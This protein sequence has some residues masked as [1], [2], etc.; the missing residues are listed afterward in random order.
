MPAHFGILFFLTSSHSFL[1]FKLSPL[2][3]NLTKLDQSPVTHSSYL[4]ISLPSLNSI[5]PHVTHISFLYINPPCTSFSFYSVQDS[6]RS[7][8]HLPYNTHI[9]LVLPCFDRHCCFLYSYLISTAHTSPYT[10]SLS[11]L[12]LQRFQTRLADHALNSLHLGLTSVRLQI[13]YSSYYL[14]P[15]THYTLSCGPSQLSPLQSPLHYLQHLL[16]CNS[17][18]QPPHSTVFS[19]SLA[20]LFL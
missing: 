16:P 4:H 9:T 5:S 17:T 2:H 12:Y 13:N 19:S 15:R 6:L 3:S 14:L 8:I 7:C 20:I 11:L 1:L 10:L 18:M